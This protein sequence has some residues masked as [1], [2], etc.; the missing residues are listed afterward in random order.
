M[1]DQVPAGAIPVDQFKPAPQAQDDSAPPGAIPIDQFQTAEE[2]YGT[3][4]Q[5]IATGLEGAAQG[6]LG[7]LAPAAER[8]LGVDPQD[9]R[10]RAEV[11]PATHGLSEAGG[12]GAG[13]FTGGSEAALLGHAG[14]AVTGALKLGGEG[15]AIGSRLAAGATKAATELGLMQAG[16]E[17]TKVIT[18]DPDQTI[19][20]A[21]ANVGL[22][23]LIGGVTGG[24]F[25]GV[26]AAAK[27]GIDAL[28]LKEFSDRLAFRGANANPNEFLQNE[29]ENAYGSYKDMGSEVGG[30]TGL[31]AQA[32][33]KL[34]PEMSE[35]IQ[36]QVPDTVSNLLNTATSM[37]AKPF[38]YG[39]RIPGL[40]KEG[41]DEFQ[42]TV[43]NAQSPGE[44]F[45]ALNDLKK[46]FDSSIPK[47]L[48]PDNDNYHAFKE[49][50]GVTGKIRKSLE[51][52]EIWGEG[53]A[54]LQ[55][56]LNAAW[57]EAIPAVKDFEKKF[58]TKIGGDLVI[59]PT[60]FQ[61]YVNQGGN[62]T[63]QTIKQQMM[64]KFSDA[65]EKFSKA[66]DEAYEKAGV[67]NPRGDSAIPMGAIRES[68]GKQSVGAR[69]ADLWYDKIG[70]QSI[71]S[72]A[73]ALAGNAVLP[74]L[75]GAFIGKEVL[76]PVFGAIIQPIV[77]KATNLP[78]YQQAMKFGK[79]VLAGNNQL[80]NGAKTLFEGGVKTIPEHLY[81][82]NKKVEQL[83]DHLKDYEK[84][85][86]KLLNVAGNLDHYAPAHSQALA[87]T[88]AG[89]VNYLNSIRPKPVQLAPLDSKIEPTKAEKLDY[90]RK[91]SIAQN[92]L[93]ALHHIKNGTLL[94]SDVDTLKTVYPAYYNKMSQEIT[95]AMTD[96]LSNDGSVPYKLR[97]SLSLF[98]GQPLDSTLT[99]QSIQA[100]QAMYASKAPQSQNQ[101]QNKTKKGTSKLNKFADNLQTP[102]QAA[103]KRH[104]TE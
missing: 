99:P 42:K 13:I 18:Q 5:Q 49:L 27:T 3:T 60:K 55:K 43:A 72:G 40:I 8:A 56:N 14:E 26:G 37:E 67:P 80:V 39:T 51:S 22:S 70:A 87:K 75:G 83:D 84:N 17:A 85:P 76:G 79:T 92:P 69:L 74:G 31:K 25:T 64:G 90:E 12:F 6:V 65:I 20:S 103:E 59:D 52:P 30:S 89:A 66:T 36:A 86:Q 68:L 24:L 21:A 11:N 61:S 50:I 62:A 2:K 96:H 63:S 91:L 28:G 95:N 16:D 10:M 32:L 33:Q 54:G 15:A 38:K 73:G 46:E 104:M 29:A 1:G 45:D 77:E 9:I 94:P 82:D 34:M 7:P 102:G 23:T 57:S 48:T 44:I 98:L 58:M 78:A 101:P 41:V 81:A 35:E 47:N 71:G 19:G 93:M 53:V 97:Q 100:V 4:G 88:A